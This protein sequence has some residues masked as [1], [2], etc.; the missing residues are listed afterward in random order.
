MTLSLIDSLTHTT[1]GSPNRS[2]ITWFSI[3]EPPDG[4]FGYFSD[5][6]DNTISVFLHGAEL[7]GWKPDCDGTGPSATGPFGIAISPDGSVAYV[8]KLTGPTLS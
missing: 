8:H 4:K 7:I 1:V 6:T 5:N 2:G 3:A